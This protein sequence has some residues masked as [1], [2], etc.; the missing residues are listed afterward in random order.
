MRGA[1][2]GNTGYGY[3]DSL[4][5]AYSEELNRLFAQRI[6]AGSTVGNAIVAAKQDYFGGLGV[7]GVYDEKSMAEF[8][9]YGLPM[10]SVSG[11]AGAAAPRRPRRRAARS[12]RGRSGE[13]RTPSFDGQL[14]SRRS[15][16]V[17]DPATGLDAETFDVDPPHGDSPCR[18]AVRTGRPRTA[19]RSR[20][21]ARSSR[22]RSSR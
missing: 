18:A 14:R 5:V 13:R 16:L 15:Q 21:C 7:F 10:W 9:L 11:A 4:V 2:L 8:T 6:A 20:T 17:P 1:Y 22:S 19:S 12:Y 3:G